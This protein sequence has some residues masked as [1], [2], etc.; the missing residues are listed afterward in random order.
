M[1]GDHQAGH[2]THSSF[3]RESYTQYNHFGGKHFLNALQQYS[4]ADVL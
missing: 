1:A 2:S 4:A 3:V